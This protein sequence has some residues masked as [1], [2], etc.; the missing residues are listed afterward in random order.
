MEVVDEMQCSL[1]DPQVK[2][3]ID[4][5][6][7]DSKGDNKG[8]L[9]LGMSMLGDIIFKRT[10]SLEKEIHRIRKLYL[11][12][13][14]EQ[15]IFAY[16]VARSINAKRIVEYGTSFG[17]STTYFAAAVKDN[18]GGIVIGSE[19]NPEKHAIASQNLADAGLSEFVDIRLGNACETLPQQDGPV[20]LLLMDGVKNLYLPIIKRMIP[21]LRLGAIVLS[22]NVLSFKKSL[23]PYREFLQNPANG[24]YSMT[25]P[26]GPGLEYS[27]KLAELNPKE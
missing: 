19:L 11:P 9:K 12:L 26:F 25:L 27:V 22:D 7:A 4:R 21:H 18:G 16:L 2:V 14:R 13:T 17:I 23:A 24:F 20:D 5:L 15:G 6:H 8:F 3:V 1:F 10:P